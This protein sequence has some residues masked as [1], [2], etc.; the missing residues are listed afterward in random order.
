MTSRYPS[1]PQRPKHNQYGQYGQSGSGYPQFNGAANHQQP[2]QR[3]ANI[4]GIIAVVIAALAILFSFVPMLGIVAIVPSLIAICLGIAGVASSTY[5]D[6]RGWAVAGIVT[7]AIGV[8][9]SIV[10]PIIM[11]SVF[12]VG[13]LKDQKEYERPPEPTPTPSEAPSTPSE[14]EDNNDPASPESET[15]VTP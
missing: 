8:F 4:P 6:N 2:A 14:R 5:Q 10:M 12:L 1:N 11:T 15:S 3:K 9:M 13:L 7:G